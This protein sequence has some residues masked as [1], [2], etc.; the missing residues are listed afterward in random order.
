M[1]GNQ[2]PAGSFG[3]SK[4]HLALISGFMLVAVTSLG[5][6]TASAAGG[7]DGT[8]TGGSCPVAGKIGLKPPLAGFPSTD[9]TPPATVK[10]SAKSVKGSLCTGGTVDGAN[11]LSM[12]TSGSGT[13]PHSS[14]SSLV[15]ANSVTFTVTVKWKVAKGTPKLNPSTITI[16]S[17][18]GGVAGDGNATF[19]AT[20]SVT[21]GSFTGNSVT[22]H[23]ETTSMSGDL[24]TACNGKGIKKL[25][26]T[27]NST[28]TLN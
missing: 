6:T 3:I 4:K 20:G 19:D 12:K 28:F 24:A 13:T 8:G 22:A 27:A 18:T 11:V 23:I 10:I 9:T 7:V 15:G 16:T 25:A 14:C 17:A 2:S 5:I 26:F 1:K 21:A